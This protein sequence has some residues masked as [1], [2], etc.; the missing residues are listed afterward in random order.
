MEDN[1]FA[2]NS[3]E[4]KTMISFSTSSSRGSNVNNLQNVDLEDMQKMEFEEIDPPPHSL[5]RKE[6]RTSNID[7]GMCLNH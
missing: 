6:K 4:A 7:G 1:P 5:S 2:N 3:C